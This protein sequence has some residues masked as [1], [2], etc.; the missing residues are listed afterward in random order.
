MKK[1]LIILL[2][3]NIFALSKELELL[4]KD[5]KEYRELESEAIKQRH[6]S[7]KYDW[8]GTLDFNSNIDRNHSFSD[9]KDKNISNKNRKVASIGFT[10]SIFESGG[11]GF[12]MD[13]ADNRFIYEN[14][15]WENQNSQLIYTIYNILLEIKKR[16]IEIEQ[17]KVRLINKNIEEIIKRIQYDAGKTDIIELNNAIMS[18]NLVQKELISLENIKKDRVQELA[19]YTDL[20]YEEIEIL[21]FKP[22]LKKDF[23]DKNYAIL[24][25]N[26]K[27][28]A[29]NSEYLVKKS[30][31]LPKLSLS[32]KASYSNQDEKFKSMIKDTNQDDASSSGS[33]ILSMPLYDYTKSSKLEESKIEVLKQKALVNDLK[34]ETA[35]EYEQIF[36][37]IDTYIKQNETTNNNIKLYDELIVANKISSEV[38][39]TS[40]YD[41]E[42]L[43]NTRIINIFDLKINEI[44]ILQEYA[45]LYFKIKE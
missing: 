39:M 5:K 23:L 21:D 40:K 8:I 12:K 42:I 14:L 27:V 16:D 19:K 4:Q 24:E 15:S 31:Y 43:E 33:L 45:N 2:F 30:Q 35:Y 44:N 10:Q 22:S 7:Q 37:K 28:D 25:A 11:I 17:I 9:E 26:A 32:A 38:G 13:Y 1:I 34:N 36:T 6:N 18:K 3:V 41:L 20:D 29:L